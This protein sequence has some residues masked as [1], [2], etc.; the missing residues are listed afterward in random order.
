MFGR[1][2]ENRP[3]ANPTLTPKPQRFC[4]SRWQRVATGLGINDHSLEPVRPYQNFSSVF[5]LS[6]VDLD[7]GAPLS[8]WVVDGQPVRDRINR[9]VGRRVRLK[10]TAEKTH[11]ET[12]RIRTPPVL[13]CTLKPFSI[14]AAGALCNTGRQPQSLDPHKGLSAIWGL[15]SITLH[16]VRPLVQGALELRVA[17]P[18]SNLMACILCWSIENREVL[19]VTCGRDNWT[20][21][22]PRYACPPAP[23]GRTRDQLGV[24]TTPIESLPNLSPSAPLVA[25][26]PHTPVPVSARWVRT[27][28]IRIEC[29]A[30]A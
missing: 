10:S 9:A 28:R 7:V 2:G 14:T 6:A 8:C 19:T 27:L 13:R 4:P 1:A 5:Y 26:G 18:A 17:T 22:Q 30:N 25:C 24:W 3:H 21:R 16:V 15:H 29:L 11:R 12:R 23:R 20:N